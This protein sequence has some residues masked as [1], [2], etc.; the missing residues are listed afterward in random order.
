MASSSSVASNH[1]PLM[2]SPSQKSPDLLDIISPQLQHHVQGAIQF[3]KDQNPTPKPDSILS[4]ELSDIRSNHIAS[5]ES[6][7]S[8]EELTA[9][10][11]SLT[12]GDN[13]EN[14]LALEE[15]P[16]K[17]GRTQFKQ[18]KELIQTKAMSQE[19]MLQWR[20]L[21]RGVRIAYDSLRCHYH[22]EYITN[23]HVREATKL[24]RSDM[25]AFS[26]M[27]KLGSE[28]IP[29]RRADQRI[30]GPIP[31]VEIGDIFFYRAEL[32]LLGLHGPTQA[33]ISYAPCSFVKEKE[34][35]AISVVASGGYEDDRE[36]GDELL[37]YTGSGGKS[38]KDSH[39][40]ADQ[41]L[42][43]GNLALERSMKYGTEVRVIRGMQ[44]APNS[45]RKLYVYDGLYRVI[46][47]RPSNS[48]SGCRLY[49]FKLLRIQGQ[50]QL[51]SKTIRIAAETKAK[52]AE[53]TVPSGY[54]SPDISGKEAITVPFF[55][56]V[57]KKHDPMLYE[58]LKSP[59][60]PSSSIQS[61]MKGCE[62]RSTCSD[63]CSC[64]DRNGGTFAYD[65][66]VLL[67]GRP[68]VYECGNG[69]HCPATCSNRVSQK[70]LRY[71]LEVFRSTDTK[72]G[73]R[74]LDPIPAGTFICEF[75]G[76]VVLRDMVKPGSEYQT[77]LIDPRKF[78]PRWHY[79]GDLSAVFPEWKPAES[80]ALEK[81][82]EYILDIS[83]RN[84]VASYISHSDAPNAF[85]QFVLY[86][87]D[88]VDFPRMA[89]FAMENIP[90][91]R[92]ITLDYG[93]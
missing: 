22:L 81:Q 51:G 65:N 10:K 88:N 46:D 30:L 32:S 14:A 45:N 52:L 54:V 61:A 23:P 71:L 60:Y 50:C 28:L 73:V 55:N 31:G 48:E 16:M 64:K 47:C 43:R 33:G 20:A 3:R 4:S 93:W 56:D 36:L 8:E 34:P 84:N 29:Y 25:K 80:P 79:W 6:D 67:Q 89:V 26:E 91:L 41:S 1:P 19:D 86:S 7:D 5:S 49:Q 57:D 9:Y 17:R 12:Q 74:S 66:G 11:S 92:D 15:T 72:W 40:S 87:H 37:L 70:G 44:L 21:N 90:P 24:D 78:P 82:P 27:N 39:V 69:C 38:R 83:K 77:T 62:C 35:I 42:E 63:N 85:I 75:S 13:D 59:E 18:P 76:D 2:A 58:Y 53:R 68:V